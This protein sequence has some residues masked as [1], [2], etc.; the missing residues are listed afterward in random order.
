MSAALRLEAPAKLNLELRVVGRRP[1]GMHLLDGHFVLLDIADRLLLMAQLTETERV[2]GVPYRDGVLAG[3]KD[4]ADE[5]GV[6]GMMLRDMGVSIGDGK[7]A[8]FRDGYR[9]RGRKPARGPQSLGTARLQLIG[10]CRPV[11][12]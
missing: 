7:A 9:P 4:W 1:D 8:G 2:D 10:G 3:V 12:I 5:H 11:V 6:T